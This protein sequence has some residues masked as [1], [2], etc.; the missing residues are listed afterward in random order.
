MSAPFFSSE[1]WTA[2]SV[3]LLVALSVAACA[4]LPVS[5]ASKKSTKG[6]TVSTKTPALTS[7]KVPSPSPSLGL[8][9]E[10]HVTVDPTQMLAGKVVQRTAAGVKLISDNGLGLIS[11]N[12]LGLI[13]DN[14]AGL[15]SDNGL[16]LISDNGLGLVSNNSAGF[17]VLQADAGA[18][19]ALQPVEGMVVTAVN[20]FTGKVIAGPVATKADGSYKLGFLK[21]PD[22]N[23]GIVAG[24]S[25]KAPVAK[26]TYASLI[27]PQ[28]KPVVTSDTSRALTRY[29]LGVLPS[30]VQPWVDKVKAGTPP[31][32]DENDSIY[33]KQLKTMLAK[34][35][36]QRMI[37][38][39]KQENGR[40]GAIALAISRR[41]ISFVDLS[42][43][44]Y[45]EF[46]RL[47]EEAR[48]FGESVQP[49]PEPSLVDQVIK[50][51][52][53]KEIDTKLAPL[54]KQ[55]GMETARADQLA[56]AMDKKGTEI[57]QLLV[58]MMIAHQKEI[59]QPVEDLTKP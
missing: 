26:F 44:T 6:T 48:L 54:L 39:D 34:I 18:S 46:Y 31:D 57:G 32:I 2:R 20:L 17:R 28:A 10:G 8:L 53:D 3:G 4:G 43:S 40:E 36:A 25:F 47:T 23:I 38:A 58:L 49:A 45:Q 22:K 7:G 41:L 51:A 21:Q 19:N 5:P 37:E 30:R 56:G 55:Y 52:Q 27:A 11:D 1:G 42:G 33:E 15:I 35:P 59:F 50:L 29:L 24:V 9:L 13:S 16:G 12:G 14:S